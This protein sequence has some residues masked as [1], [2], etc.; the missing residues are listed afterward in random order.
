MGLVVAEDRAYGGASYEAAFDRA[1]RLATTSLDG[2]VR[3]YDPGLRLLKAATAPGG[4]RPYGVAFSPGQRPARGRLRGRDRGRR[5]RRGDAAAAVRGRHGRG[6][7]RRP[8]QGGVVGGRC[9]AAR[10]RAVAGRRRVP[11]PALGRGWAGR[12]HRPAARPEHGH[13]PAWAVERAAGLRR[14]RPPARVL[15]A[16]GREA[17]PRAGHGRPPRPGGRVASLGRRGAGRLQLRGPGAARRDVLRSPSGGSRPGRR[18]RAGDGQN[19]APGSRSRVEEHPEPTLNGA[20]LALDATR[21]LSARGRAGRRALRARHAMVAAPVRP[22]RRQLGGG[23]VPGR[24]G[25]ERHRRRAAVVAAYATARS[26][27]TGSATGRSC[28][29]STRTPTGSAGCCGRR[30]ATTRPRRAGRT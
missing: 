22:R 5:A 18:R 16:D 7:E 4:K 14:G 25:G 27:G 21:P 28:W 3:L 29:R 19:A 1:G 24:L 6:G 8:L 20:R 23:P 15:G 10:R 2:K 12:A 13:R 11:G 9:G 30:G 17:G 26:A